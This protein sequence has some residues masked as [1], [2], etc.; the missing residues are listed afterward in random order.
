MI[1]SEYTGAASDNPDEKDTAKRLMNRICM[2]DSSKP[3]C[4][5]WGQCELEPE[6]LCYCGFCPPRWNKFVA[7]SFGD[8]TKL[9]RI[10]THEIYAF[11]VSHQKGYV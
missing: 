9:R 7:T 1:G 8:L 10:H 11:Q 5:V 3:R 2:V 6:G 4:T